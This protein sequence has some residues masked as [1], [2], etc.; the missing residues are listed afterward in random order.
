MVGNPLRPD[1]DYFKAGER[2]YHAYLEAGEHPR[3]ARWAFWL[4]FRLFALRR[5]SAAPRDGMLVPSG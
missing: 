3:A 1:D 4:C 2:I 5:N